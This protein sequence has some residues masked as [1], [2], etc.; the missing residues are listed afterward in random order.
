MSEETCIGGSDSENWESEV[1]ELN[2]RIRTLEAELAQ[3]RGEIDRYKE[4]EYQAV[5]RG[6]T[7]KSELE[8]AKSQIA[9]GRIDCACGKDTAS[10]KWAQCYN[11]RQKPYDELERAEA[12]L[13]A[14]AND[15]DERNL[16]SPRMQAIARAY[17]SAKSQTPASGEKEGK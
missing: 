15:N 2:E 5:N 4:L 11:C 7:L 1:A 14:L 13:R 8:R 10:V 9:E 17:F 12:A 6:D 16:V 3:A